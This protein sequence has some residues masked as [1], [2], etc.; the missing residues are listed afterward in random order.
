[1]FAIASISRKF[2]D[3]QG[4]AIRACKETGMYVHVMIIIMLILLK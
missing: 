4:K 2:A 1:M 3:P